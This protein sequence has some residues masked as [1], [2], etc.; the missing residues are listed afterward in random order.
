[1]IGDGGVD[2]LR[3]QRVPDPLP[4]PNEVIIDVLCIFDIFNVDKGPDLVFGFDIDHVLYRPSLGCPCSFRYFKYPHPEHLT[5]F[6][7]EE[8]IV[9]VGGH[10]KV[11]EKVLVTD[12]ASFG[13]TPS[14]VLPPV[15]GQ[16]GA[17]DIPE[18]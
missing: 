6:G 7:K 18:V 14:P 4:A 13:P 12:G 10:E 8:H 2:K 5:I 3:I 15:F 1:M 11:F 16:F 9:M 17:F